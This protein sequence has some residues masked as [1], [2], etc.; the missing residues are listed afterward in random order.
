MG[1][2]FLNKMV[3][4]SLFI[5]PTLTAFRTL[6]GSFHAQRAEVPEDTILANWPATGQ[7][8]G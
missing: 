4:L 5:S 2:V 8:H 3:E 1:M 6:L 7:R